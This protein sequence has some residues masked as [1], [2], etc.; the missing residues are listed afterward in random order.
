MQVSVEA[1]SALERRMT[2]GVPAARI[3][4]AVDKSLQ[5]TARRAKVPASARARCR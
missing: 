4:S 2:V 5:Q 3:E 1:T